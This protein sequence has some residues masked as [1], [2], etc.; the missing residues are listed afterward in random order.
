MPWERL[1]AQTSWAWCLIYHLVTWPPIMVAQKDMCWKRACKSKGLKSLHTPLLLPTAGPQPNDNRTHTQNY[2]IIRKWRKKRKN[3][4]KQKIVGK[5]NFP[6]ILPYITNI[7][8]QYI[9]I[10]KVAYKVRYMYATRLQEASS[11][12]YMGISSLKQ[13]GTSHQ[14]GWSWAHQSKPRHRP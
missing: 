7:V 13:T 8:W 14:G 3:K 4:E 1:K 12:W 2:E 11:M 6:V 5:K 10:Y 9:H